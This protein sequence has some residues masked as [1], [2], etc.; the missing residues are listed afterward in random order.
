[1]APHDEKN[2]PMADK[3]KISQSE[4]MTQLLSTISELEQVVASLESGSLN[5]L[6]ASQGSRT[7]S[8][9]ISASEQLSEFCEIVPFFPVNTPSEE[10]ALPRD[11]IEMEE[12]IQ[13][14]DRVLPSFGTWQRGWAFLLQKVRSILPQAINTKLS[15]WGLT[16]ILSILLV[17]VLIFSV[18]LLPKPVSDSYPVSP[19]LTSPGLGP[20]AVANQS[21]LTQGENPPVLEAPADPLPVELAPAI[22]TPLT[23][24]QSLLAYIQQGIVSLTTQYP[25]GL[26]QTME[27]DFANN[28]LILTIGDEWY[29][30]ASQ[31][32]DSLTQSIWGRAQK[33]SFHKLVL[34]GQDGALVARS[35]IVGKNMVIFRRLS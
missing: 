1:M 26:I 18:L 27:P 13:G 16:S 14:I 2:L 5:E 31:K 34:V 8:A 24:E 23:P 25:P 10:S 32:Q 11:E 29:N 4:L 33:L 30:L 19:P 15:D 21:E 12:E 7:V 20:T 9:L 28:R 6:Q 22:E 35:P 3:N 17:S